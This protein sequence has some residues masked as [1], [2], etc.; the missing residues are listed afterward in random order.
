MNHPRVDRPSRPRP[1]RWRAAVALVV[2]SAALVAVAIALR[3]GSSSRRT[4]AGPPCRASTGSVP[5]PLDAAQAANATTIAAVGKRLGLADHAV[6]IALAAALQESGLHN[7]SHG[8]RDSLGLFQQRPSQGWGTPEAILTPRLAAARF[9]ERLAQIPG[10]RSL[11]VTTAAQ[12]V[13]RSA[14]PNAYADWEPEARDLAV[15]L[16]GERPAGLTCRFA[17]PSHQVDRAV[18]LGA[19]RDELGSPGVGATVTSARGWTIATWLVGHADQQGV[20]RVAFAGRAWTRS[21]G[22]WQVDRT[23]GSAVQFT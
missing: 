3:P 19:M 11:S 2:A 23:S 1:S 10:W 16:T 21:T 14:A 13:Q 7:L 15:S 6:T 18:V 22:T 4:P 8:D 17:G 12:R 20:T 9:Y 5:V